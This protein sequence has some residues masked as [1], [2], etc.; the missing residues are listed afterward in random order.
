MYCRA[1]HGTPCTTG[2]SPVT[3]K[4]GGFRFLNNGHHGQY[5]VVALSGNAVV[6]FWNAECHV[7]SLRRLPWP[8]R[9]E[10]FKLHHY[11]WSPPFDPALRRLI[12]STACPTRKSSTSERLHGNQ[13]QRRRFHLR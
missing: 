7:P 5:P 11:R 8:S 2:P 3:N 9:P 10:K 1:V 6:L 13:V 12:P 4:V